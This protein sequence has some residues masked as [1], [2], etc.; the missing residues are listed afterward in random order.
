MA[1]SRIIGGIELGTHKVVVLI[2]EITGK[3]GLTI[4]GQGE[5]SSR[6]IEKGRIVDF[7]AACS[8]AHAALEAAEKSAGCSIQAL[9]MAQTGSHLH[10]FA[11]RG[12]TVV[13]SSDGLVTEDDL[14]RAISN[15]RDK[16]LPDDR[17]F[18]HHVRAG[19]RLDGKAVSD[20]VGM[21]GEE[22]EVGYW[23]VT[24][25]AREVSNVLQISN[26][27]GL[28]VYDLVA[29]SMASACIVASEAERE[30]GA[31]VLD[32]GRGTT[33]YVLYRGGHM[34]RSGVVPAGGDHMTN[35]LACALRIPHKDAERIKLSVGQAIVEPE[36][37]KDRVWLFGD[38]REG[39]S[40]IGNRNVPRASIQ[41]VLHAR[42]DE[43][44]R[45][46]K[47]ACA[48]ETGAKDIPSG[49]ILTGGASQLPGLTTLAEEV[50]GMSVT[51]KV[52]PGGATEELRGPGYS[53][54]LGLLY[55]GLSMM[56]PGRSAERRR[57]L[58][59]RLLKRVATFLNLS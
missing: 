28:E 5:C 42:C 44:L 26:H 58:S 14:E 38:V 43:I 31:L 57:A 20:P 56:G 53:T 22:L 8:C 12:T 45:L 19:I 35:D 49:V 15:A 34:A 23:H 36:A 18:L 29:S 50:F 6:G 48:V 21:R 32:I 30:A 33:D 55:Y 51:G 16:E 25:D 3:R 11:Q 2:G 37:R 52:N 10:G 9:Y 7:K 47:K 27:Y 54:V 46:V 17:V 40:A 59:P 4:I 39:N 24:G 13:S 41:M 1:A